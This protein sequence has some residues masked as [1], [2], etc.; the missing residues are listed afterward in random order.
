M[1]QNQ[2]VYVKPASV[3]LAES[4]R[5]VAAFHDALIDI[6]DECGLREGL[7]FI[8]SLVRDGIIRADSG[9]R[10]KLE[11]CRLTEVMAA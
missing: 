3:P 8:G 7:R 1:N 11:V 4:L 10:L 6:I 5:E 9:R 2:Y